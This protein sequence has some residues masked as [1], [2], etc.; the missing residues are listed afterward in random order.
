MTTLAL[1]VFT[2]Q[3]C[4]GTILYYLLGTCLG[5]QTFPSGFL[6][7]PDLMTAVIIQCAVLTLRSTFHSTFKSMHGFCDAVTS[8]SDCS[9]GPLNTSI[10]SQ[11]PVFLSLFFQD[12]CATLTSNTVC[13][14]IASILYQSFHDK[15]KKYLCLQ[16]WNIGRKRSIFSTSY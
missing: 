11:T 3:S 5:Y 1:I 2:L 6:F 9:C 15:Q 12:Y 10:F 8:K 16:V 13:T 14:L 4:G 7:F